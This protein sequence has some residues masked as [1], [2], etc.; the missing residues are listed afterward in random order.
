MPGFAFSRKRDIDRVL[1]LIEGPP[2]KKNLPELG[3]SQNK[4]IFRYGVLAQTP[5][6]GIAARSGTTVTSASC[7]VYYIDAGT[8]TSYGES[9][10]VY[11]IAGSAI[12]G[13]TYIT[14]KLVGTVWIADAEDCG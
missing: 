7:T 12:A 2:G 1:K 8:I 5:S 10:D 6:G 3:V 4:K 14:A 13:S 9:I 11:N